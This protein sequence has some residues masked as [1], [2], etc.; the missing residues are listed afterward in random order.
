[1]DN[2]EFAN[3]DVLEKLNDSELVR[4]VIQGDNLHIHTSRASVAKRILENR[5]QTKQVQIA[6]DVSRVTTQLEGTGNDIKEIIS[7]TDEI[8]SVLAFIKRNWLPNKPLWLKIIVFFVSTVL[9][10]IVLNLVSVWIG[11][12]LF[13]W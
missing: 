9:I 13:H 4:E 1:M 10:G 7:N 12:T 2:R 3:F 5:R 11:K 6:E 8:V